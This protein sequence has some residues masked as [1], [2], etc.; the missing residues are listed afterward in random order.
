MTLGTETTLNM[1]VVLHFWGRKNLPTKKP[2]FGGVFF[3]RY[4]PRRLGSGTSN[5]VL[6]GEKLGH[7]ISSG[8]MVW[9]ELMSKNAF[10]EGGHMNT[11][12]RP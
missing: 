11:H 8:M 3:R 1:F 7:D 12:L 10:G 4:G 9:G 5:A 6:P 2:T